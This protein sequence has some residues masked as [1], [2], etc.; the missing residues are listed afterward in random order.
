MPAISTQHGGGVKEKI[1]EQ[2]VE[3]PI[4]QSF[5]SVFDGINSFTESLDIFEKYKKVHL[6]I[7][8]NTVD[9]IKIFGMSEPISLLEVY[10]PTKISTTIHRRLYYEDW[11]DPNDSSIGKGPKVH[12]RSEAADEFVDKH[13]RVVVL[14]SPGAGKTTF[15]KF[16]ALCY[17]NDNLF[18]ESKLEK[19]KLPFFIHLPTL[20]DS[21]SAVEDALC[22]DLVQRTD[23]HAKAFVLR[24][25]V[26]GEA[27][28]LLDSLDEVPD[29][30]KKKVL[31]NVKKFGKKYPKV[32]IV[33][34]CRIADYVE[35]LEDYCEVEI[36][37]LTNTAI[38]KIV[39]AW[40]KGDTKKS[41]ALLRHIKADSSISSLTETPLLLS[42]ICIQY[43]NDLNIP[44]RKAELYKRCTDALIRDW[45]TT[46]GFRRDSAFSSL[47]DERKA[48]LF[49]HTA[50][51][52]LAKNDM[53]VFPNKDLIAV[54]G[55]YCSRFGIESSTAEEILTEIESHHGII[56]KNSADTWV[57]SH[58]SFQEYFTACHLIATRKDVQYVKSNYDNFKLSNVMSFITGLSEDPT[59]ILVY[60]KEKANLTNLQSFPPM[61]RRINQINLLYRC[62]NAGASILP[63]TRKELL[64]FIAKSHLEM[65]RIF[66]GGGVLPM[67]LLEPDGIRHVYYSF[68]NQRK[69]L[70]EPL[71]NLR[72]LSNEML[73]SPARDYHNY[74]LSLATTLAENLG[75]TNQ[76]DMLTKIADV[77]TLLM[78]LVTTCPKDVI[79]ITKLLKSATE[80]QRY[81]TMNQLITQN[82]DM[83]EKS[84]C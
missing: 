66:L 18:D 32:K 4:K 23:E 73:L 61:A 11:I 60:I 44:N 80:N 21:D 3:G 43:K 54:I 24:R 57:F 37:K 19:R 16:L 38:I 52:F 45:D 33:I 77:L 5:K 41:Q 65:I 9:K 20:S 25:L 26:S 79:V 83:I 64:D 78:P 49:G 39:K 71:Q 53:Y 34:S 55:N 14:A 1:L 15:L 47:T 13:S 28:V 17:S 81:K 6:E 2:A 27:I 75:A 69:T 31:D 10:A 46:R 7:L 63:E 72:K 29:N 67:P 8:Q 22:H 40:F 74:A 56:E 30:I 12:H 42:L 50:T 36:A 48:R 84:Y 62:M 82:I 58:T 59:E 35:T 70:S 51:H 76:T 68:G